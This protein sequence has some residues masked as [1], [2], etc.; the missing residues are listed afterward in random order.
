MNRRDLLRA[1]IS[2]GA[3]SGAKRVFAEGKSQAHAQIHADTHPQTHGP[4]HAPT[5]EAV[6]NGLREG[7]ARFAAGHALHPNS[8]PFRVHQTELEGQHPEAAVLCCSDS[9][10]PPEIL[11]D[12]GLGDLFSVRVA[13]N[14]ANEDEIASME[15]AVEHLGVHVCI[16]LGHYE[17]GAVTAVVEGGHLP[18]ELEHLVTH[19]RTAEHTVQRVSSSMPQKVLIEATVRANV[20]ESIRDILMM[21]KPVRE[22]V[23]QGKLL[24]VGAVYRLT[25]GKVEWLG[26]HPEQA[27]FL[28]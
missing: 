7:N 14:V 6:L 26:S 8:G 5:P 28:R 9:R 17:C 3:F 23:R 18:P 27:R 10:V 19:I 25:D 21:A 11:F 24:V 20:W 12:H 22:Q 4:T 2:V 16:V 13:G 1:A 15:Y